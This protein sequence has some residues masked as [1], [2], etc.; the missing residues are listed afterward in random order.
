MTT[1]NAT[2]TKTTAA[3]G[4]HSTPKAAARF[5]K[6]L[7]SY[8]REEYAAIGDSIDFVMD[9]AFEDKG[10]EERFFGP[11]AMTIPVPRWSEFSDVLGAMTQT[12]SAKGTLSA[13]QERE[14]FLRYNYACY[15]LSGLIEVQ[16]NRKSAL[17]AKQ[18]VMWAQR[19]KSVRE[20]VACCNMALVVAMARRT[21]VPN[22]DFPDLVSEGNMALLRS[23]EKFDV[24]RGFKFSTYACRSI[25]KSFNRLATKTSRYRE[26]FPVE[27]DPEFERSDWD[28]RRHEMQQEHSIDVLREII[29]ANSAHLTDVEKTVI[30]ERFALISSTENGKM[31][32]LAQV[33]S[34][35]GLTNERVRQI[36]NNAL[37]K[38]R[39]AMNKLHLNA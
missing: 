39:E 7:N 11:D 15:R 10:A 14:L 17:R 21:R 3:A 23:I 30:I 38:L 28:E 36:Q 6:D 20:D 16:A 29:A 26:R 33:G 4:I 13:K 5:L 22:V 24:S 8:Q 37:G 9:E 12:R 34:I 25:L 32:T 18:M 19:I 2:T 31:R 1:T 35:V 27:F